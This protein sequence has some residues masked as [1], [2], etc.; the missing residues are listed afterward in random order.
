MQEAIGMPAKHEYQGWEHDRERPDYA[1]ERRGYGRERP[2]EGEWEWRPYD[3][4]HRGRG[5]P[6]YGRA[7]EGS[8]GG[9]YVGRGPKGYR[10]S[11]ERIREDVCDRL[12]DHPQVDASEIEVEVHDGEVTLSGTVESRYAKR[13]AEDIADAVSGIQDIHNRLRVAQGGEQPH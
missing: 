10:R 12:A 9:P 5:H 4:V 1:W 6:G 11:D 3:W 8:A 13:L 7:E 2:Y